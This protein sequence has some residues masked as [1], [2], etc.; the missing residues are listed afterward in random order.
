MVVIRNK[1]DTI[2]V[3]SSAVHRLNENLYYLANKR[4]V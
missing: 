2:Y 4:G 3:N 1:F